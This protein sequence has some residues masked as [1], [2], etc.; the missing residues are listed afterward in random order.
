VKFPEWEVTDV[1]STQALYESSGGCTQGLYISR[2]GMRSPLRTS[3]P[4]VEEGSFLVAINGHRIDSFGMG[5]DQDYI[6]D[7]VTFRDLMFMV[8][9]LAFDIEI[10]TCRSGISATHRVGTA[11]TPDSGAGLVEVLEPRVEGVA[12]KYEMFGD[13]LVMEMTINHIDEVLRTRNDPGPS[14]WMQPPFN[15]EPRLIIAYVERST[16]ASSV[17]PV[18]ATVSK[19]NGQ[20]VRTL[21]EYRACFAPSEGSELWSLETDMGLV[22]RLQFNESVAR[23]YRQGS[24]PDS[25]Y[26]LTEAV[27]AAAVRLGLADGGVPRGWACA[28][29]CSAAAGGVVMLT[30]TQLNEAP[31]DMRPVR[32]AGPLLVDPADKGPRR[33]SARR[34][35]PAAPLSGARMAAAATPLAAAW[36]W[37]VA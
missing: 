5:I 11:W 16:W 2:I 22:M 1:P 34:A 8:P 21:A 32:A 17:F 30:P 10:E 20:S 3:L 24:T 29:N 6:P 23:Q 36:H 7:R 27:V 4:R 13:V 35:P 12:E 14:R 9:D 33:V 26:L 37:P 28:H 25:R 19:V 31:R 15:V 18:G